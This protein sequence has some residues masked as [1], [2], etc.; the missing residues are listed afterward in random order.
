MG[1]A[2]RSSGDA[3]A[4]PEARY[5]RR[6]VMP[7]LPPI[8]PSALLEEPPLGG[9]TACE[10]NRTFAADIDTEGFIRKI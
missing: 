5:S 3:S 8:V 2:L 1:P 10:R 9:Y 7:R 4:A 6:V